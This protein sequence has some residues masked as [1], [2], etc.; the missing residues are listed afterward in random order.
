MNVLDRIMMD[1]YNK[2]IRKRDDM[3]YSRLQEMGYDIS[4][5]E[6]IARRCE[7]RIY[8][9]DRKQEL[10]IDTGTGNQK[11]VCYFS[12]LEAKPDPD[13]PYLIRTEFGFAPMPKELC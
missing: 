6:A 2:V 7:V 9:G 1:H 5:K 12:E 4:D 13:K 3:M 10:W 8:E 11:L